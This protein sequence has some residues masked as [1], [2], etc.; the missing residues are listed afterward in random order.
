MTKDRQNRVLWVKDGAQ[1]IEGRNHGIE[2]IVKK[3]I[4][5]PYQINR[6]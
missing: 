6:Q 1:P 3:S 5:E 2:K 4:R